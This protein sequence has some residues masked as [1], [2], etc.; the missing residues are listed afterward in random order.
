MLS[1]ILYNAVIMSK[2]Y[3]N[4]N[5]RVQLKI[6]HSDLFISINITLLKI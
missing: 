1:K 2:N 4:K 3:Y 6:V 5:K